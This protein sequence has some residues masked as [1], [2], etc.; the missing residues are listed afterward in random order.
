MDFCWSK[1]KWKLGKARFLLESQ[2][3]EN[4]EKRSLP[5]GVVGSGRSW[6]GIAVA[7]VAFEC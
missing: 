5:R 3:H 6:T 1:I 4:R 2:E 7:E